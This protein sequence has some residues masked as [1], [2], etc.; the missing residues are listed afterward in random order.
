MAGVDPQR[1]TT[2]DTIHAAGH[3]SI[4]WLRTP[5]DLAVLF[6]ADCLLQLWDAQ[7]APVAVTGDKRLGRS[8]MLN[9]DRFKAVCTALEEASPKQIAN[10]IRAYASHCRTNPERLKNPHMRLTFDRFLVK[11]L[12]TWLAAGQQLVQRDQAVQ[13][14][15][16]DTVQAGEF[17]AR[18][19]SIPNADQRRMLMLAIEQLD[20]KR[21]RY[22]PTTSDPLVRE[23]LLHLME[24]DPCNVN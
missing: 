3:V 8:R 18:W 4:R 11:A 13:A 15:V 12:E 20:R 17:M 10:A 5:H 24:A 1:L 9:D 14:R 22:T 19:A 7:M 2:W 21:A 16:A 6:V 23:R